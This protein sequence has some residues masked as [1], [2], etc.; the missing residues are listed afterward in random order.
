MTVLEGRGSQLFL[1]YSQLHAWHAG[2]FWTLKGS[3]ALL[4]LMLERL[5]HCRI[6]CSFIW[7]T[8]SVSSKTNLWQF[9][10]KLYLPPADMKDAKCVKIFKEFSY[11]TLASFCLNICEQS[12]AASQ[13][14]ATSAQRSA[15]LAR[16]P[17]CLP[18]P[19]LPLLSLVQSWISKH[20]CS[21]M[22]QGSVVKER[23]KDCINLVRVF[24]NLISETHSIQWKFSKRVQL[25]EL[26]QN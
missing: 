26:I 17:S 3:S 4:Q 7:S 14:Q 24:F 13:V 23:E 2:R 5:I 15:R 19:H 12:F 18:P 10:R 1:D 9:L 20:T 16:G 25:T 21:S 8:W 6:F 11:Q 22:S